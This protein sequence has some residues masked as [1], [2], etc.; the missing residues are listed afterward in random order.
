MKHFKEWLSDNL[1]YV[2]LLLAV[3]LLAAVIWIGITVR[4]RIGD[5][6]GI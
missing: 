2:M 3:V 4:D 1:R 6:D 5:A